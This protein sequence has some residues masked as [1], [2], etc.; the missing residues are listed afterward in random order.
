MTAHSIGT[1]FC[2]NIVIQRLADTTDAN[3]GGEQLNVL[4]IKLRERE[5]ER[6]RESISF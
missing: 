1:T 6:E 4:L 5:R 2:L 3:S